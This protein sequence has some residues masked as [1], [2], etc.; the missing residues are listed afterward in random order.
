MES[1]N[2]DKGCKTYAINGDESNVI[3]INAAD[4][5]LKDRIE[6][7][8]RDIN[9]YKAE[10]EDAAVTDNVRKELD[11]LVKQKLDEAFG[12][13]FSEAVFGDMNVFAITETGQFIYE[14]FMEAFL[15]IVQADIDKA[16]AANKKHICELVDSKKLDAIAAEITEKSK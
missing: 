5:N 12:K 4:P 7:M 16:T 3:R 14:T 9:E 8:L 15:P 6:K 13:G 11:A 10:R 1:I 2:F